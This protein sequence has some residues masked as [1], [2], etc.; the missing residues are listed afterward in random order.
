M[1]LYWETS[2]LHSG[3]MTPVTDDNQR[4]R[5]LIRRNLT[6]A[7]NY[8]L[9]NADA[10]LIGAITNSPD[11]PAHFNVVLSGQTYGTMTRLAGNSHPV[12]VM[13]GSNWLLMG[14]AQ[15]NHYYAYRGLGT[16]FS[17][18]GLADGETIHLW[19]NHDDDAPA[20]VLTVCVL[21]QL[22]RNRDAKSQPLSYSW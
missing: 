13:R 22:R 14:N 11:S 2:G 10:K 17:T 9:M 4:V 18:E 7:F 12:Y 19:V 16:V 3:H 6:D 20:A 5:F 21:D 1:E 8:H 15:T